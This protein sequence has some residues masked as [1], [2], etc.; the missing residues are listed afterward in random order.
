MEDLLWELL[1]CWFFPAFSLQISAETPCPTLSQADGEAD[2]EQRGITS[3]GAL[4]VP[5]ILK[6]KLEEGKCATA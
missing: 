2:E 5:E 3:A 4:L 6:S 1:P